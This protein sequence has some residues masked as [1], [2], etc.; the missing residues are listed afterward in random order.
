M[1]IDQSG[2]DV[3]ACGIDHLSL[4]VIQIIPNHGDGTVFYQNI[5]DTAQP[6]DRIDQSTIFDQ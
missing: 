5:H 6:A 3:K 1:H 2:T 4:S